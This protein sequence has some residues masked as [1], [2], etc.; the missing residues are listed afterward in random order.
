MQKIQERGKKEKKEARP[1]LASSRAGIS[2]ASPSFLS[3]SCVSY[4]DEVG[5]T[6]RDGSRFQYDVAVNFGLC[7]NLMLQQP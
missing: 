2:C 4:Y 5:E 1:G 3:L 6:R 7:P